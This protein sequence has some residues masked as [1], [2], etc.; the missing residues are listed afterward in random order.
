MAKD[1]QSN[2]SVAEKVAKELVEEKVV[3][4]VGHL[5]SGMS[6]RASKIYEAA[7]LPHI[8][9]SATNPTLTRQGHKTSFRTVTN[10]AHV[11]ETLAFHAVH[12]LK[13]KRTVIVLE[14]VAGNLPGYGE[15]VAGLYTSALQQQGG[16]IV[17]TE[18]IGAN[19]LDYTPTLQKIIKI[20]PDSIFFAGLD[21]AAGKFLRQMKASK[22]DLTVL[23]PDGMC[24]ENLMQLS[25]GEAAKIS[26]ICAVENGIDSVNAASVADFEARFFRK[27]GTQP[28]A[29]SLTAYDAVNVLVNA[30]QRAQS[31][32]PKIYL[33]VLAATKNYIG[34]TG[35]ISFDE[36][37]DLTSG[38]TSLYTY[39]EKGKVLM[40][41]QRGQ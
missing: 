39:N 40:S 6:I 19:A 11:M 3:G 12:K 5:T 14:E 20:Q 36:R 25:G 4:V 28:S 31:T 35:P 13:L 2:P 30:M 21:G 38:A 23:G 9:P 24:S 10:D 22:I 37:G 27:F 26:T 41:V 34:A 1:D 17:S 7:G 33:P 18:R 15:I 32:D 16:N 8:T 29:N